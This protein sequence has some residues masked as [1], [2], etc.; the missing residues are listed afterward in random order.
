MICNYPRG[1]RRFRLSN[2]NR[3]RYMPSRPACVP[4]YL[5]LWSN[6]SSLAEWLLRKERKSA[7]GGSLHVDNGGPTFEHA[8]RERPLRMSRRNCAFCAF[9]APVSD[10]CMRKLN[11]RDRCGIW[12]SG[13]RAAQF[14]PDINDIVLPLLLVF[15][16]PIIYFCDSSDILMVKRAF[17]A[18][19]ESEGPTIRLKSRDG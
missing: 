13:E 5:W 7:R 15:L 11:D 10:H 3:R 14:A 2:Q 6:E 12:A 9:S 18:R 8:T 4:P 19:H 17:L 1:L 16:A